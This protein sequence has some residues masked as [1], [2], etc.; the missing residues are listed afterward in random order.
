MSNVIVPTV[1]KDR[2]E[3]RQY[4][5]TASD[6]LTRI[7]GERDAIKEIV[8]EVSEKFEIPKKYIKKMI[9][10]HHQMNLDTLRQEYQDVEDLYT[11]IVGIE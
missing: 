8:E 5:Q 10:I 7:A 3:I 4:L 1:E 2:A 11:S 6:S 9:N